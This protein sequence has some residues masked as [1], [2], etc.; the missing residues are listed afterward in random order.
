LVVFYNYCTIFDYLLNNPK[1]L[2][3]RL[4]K[5]FLA[6]A[7]LLIFGLNIAKAQEVTWSSPSDY[8]W[9]PFETATA[10][11]LNS[12]SNYQTGGFSSVVSSNALTPLDGNYSLKSVNNNVASPANGG[13]Y[14][15]LIPSGTNVTTATYEWSF[16][17]KYTGATGNIVDYGT[18]V[19]QN[20]A[21]WRYWLI[22]NSTTPTASSSSLGLYFTQVGGNMLCK[23]KASSSYTADLGLSYAMTAGHTY[24][25]VLK[26]LG[27]GG[28]YAI[29]IDDIAVNATAQT[30]QV[31]TNIGGQLATY[32]YSVLECNDART[33]ANGNFQWDDFKIYQPT[34]TIATVPYTPASTT[35]VAGTQ[36]VI[37]YE[38]SVTVRDVITLKVAN[39]NGASN[40]ANPNDAQSNY[41]SG[42]SLYEGPD[43]TLTD[44]SL[45]SA[46]N[47]TSDYSTIINNTAL[48]LSS[49]TQ[50]GTTYYFF[51]LVN[52]ASPITGS[53]TTFQ[54]NTPFIQYDNN[55]GSITSLS[56]ATT[57]GPLFMTGRGI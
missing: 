57:Y 25:V 32:G 6:F 2:K 27:S 3:T 37:A 13:I 4:L 14:G 5:Y 23:S 39:G 19:S 9:N 36:N 12:M 48:P 33:T 8:Y 31:Q 43:N 52:I 38:Y 30:L 35:V 40:I 53:S 34:E 55:N 10:A 49:T 16:L 11:S 22:T 17:Y 42:S 18:P 24:N 28:T 41:I 56:T 21:G 1:I 50:A 20:K 54:L 44:A 51:V 15:T 26:L 46:S 47:I 45:V 7:C 29:Y